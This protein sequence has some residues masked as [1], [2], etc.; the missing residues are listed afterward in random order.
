MNY[1]YTFDEKFEGNTLIVGQAGYRKTTFI[2]TLAK[3][4]I[5]AELKE[6]YWITKVPLS[7]Q[8]EKNVNSCF[9]KHVDFKYLQT[10]D[11]FNMD[12]T[13]FLRQKTVYN[14]SAMGKYN[15]FHQ[16]I[17]MNDVSGLVDKSDDFANFLTVSRKFGFS[18]VYVFHTMY[19]TRSS[20]QIILAQIKFLIF[21]QVLWIRRL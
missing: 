16:L 12:L 19:P 15:I 10:V 21:F 18:C 5:F 7:D 2:Q 1:E 9:N 11:E 6:I 13:F 14:N 8:R 4:N 3:N 17:I 20:W